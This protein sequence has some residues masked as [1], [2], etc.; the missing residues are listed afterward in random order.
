LPDGDAVSI[1][2]VG[3]AARVTVRPNTSTSGNGHL[4]FIGDST[5]TIR[6]SLEALI[7]RSRSLLSAH[8]TSK[9]FFDR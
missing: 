7:Q 3:L 6:A 9:G 8:H 2:T 1:V 4:A 5:A